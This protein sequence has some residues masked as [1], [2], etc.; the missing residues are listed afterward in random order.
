MRVEDELEINLFPSSVTSFVSDT[1]FLNFRIFTL[2]DPRIQS[3][4]KNMSLSMILRHFVDFKY[5]TRCVH[6]HVF[7]QKPIRVE[8]CNGPL[9]A[10]KQASSE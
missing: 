9:C 4:L 5:I 10:G 7:Y 6:T 2:C 3:W 1:A 8:T